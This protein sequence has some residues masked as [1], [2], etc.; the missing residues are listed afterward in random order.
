MGFVSEPDEPSARILRDL[1]RRKVAFVIVV[2]AANFA[3]VGVLR[4]RVVREQR[5]RAGVSYKPRRTPEE[6]IDRLDGRVPCPCCGR[7]FH[8]I[9]QEAMCERSRCDSLNR[10]LGLPFVAPWDWTAEEWREAFPWK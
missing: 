7:T 3:V 4:G 10:T 8:T 1:P 5:L 2:V 6:V 9:S